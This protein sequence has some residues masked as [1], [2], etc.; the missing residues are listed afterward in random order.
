MKAHYPNFRETLV[1]F[2]FLAFGFTRGQLLAFDITTTKNLLSNNGDSRLDENGNSMPSNAKNTALITKYESPYRNFFNITNPNSSLKRSTIIGS[3]IVYGADGIT[4]GARACDVNGGDTVINVKID[5]NPNTIGPIDA[6]N[7]GKYT[8]S[9]YFHMGISINANSPSLFVNKV[10]FA[11]YTT[12]VYKS[13]STS[14]FNSKIYF[15]TY[16][17]IGIVNITDSPNIITWVTDN[18]KLRS[19]ALPNGNS[20]DKEVKVFFKS[21]YNTLG[22]EML[23]NKS[24]E[25]R[26]YVSRSNEAPY[27]STSTNVTTTNL[28]NYFKNGTNYQPATSFSD[29]SAGEIRLNTFPFAGYSNLNNDRVYYDNLIT[30]PETRFTTLIR[31]TDNP[32]VY[33]SIGPPSIPDTEIPCG[34]T[35]IATS[36]I[37]SSNLYT[38]IPTTTLSLN[39]GSYSDSKSGTTFTTNDSQIA[40]RI[41]DSS[42]TDVT[43]NATL[44]IGT[45]YA[46]YMYDDDNSTTGTD[47]TKKRMASVT[48]KEFHITQKTTTWN[49]SSWNNGTPTLNT[50]V[51]I[52]GNYDTAVNGNLDACNLTVN[53]GYKLDI[54]GNTQVRVSNNIVNNNL[55]STNDYNFIVQNDGNLIQINDNGTFTG[56]LTLY[57]NSAPV[58]KGHYVYWGSPVDGQNL[59]QFSPNTLSSRFYTYNESNDLFVWIDPSLN[60]FSRA[61]GYAIRAPNN[62]YTSVRTSYTGKFQGNPYTGAFTFPIVKSENVIANNGASVEM[63]NT[64]I[65]NPYPSNLDLDKFFTINSGKIYST[66]YFWTNTNYNPPMQGVNYPSNLPTKPVINNYAIYNKSGGTPAPFGWSGGTGTTTTV[67]LPITPNNIVKPGQGF[68][69][70][71]SGTAPINNTISFNNSTRVTEQTKTQFYSRVNSKN[72]TETIDRYW[73]TLK[74]PLDFVTPILIAYK[75][76]ASNVYE[77]DYDSEPLIDSGDNFYSIIP[78]HHLTIQGR[79]GP[80]D[81]NDRVSLGMGIGLEGNHTISLSGKEG[82]FEQGQPI[83]LYDKYLNKEINLQE[84]SYNFASATGIYDDR[85][86]LSY[87]PN[88]TLGNGNVKNQEDILIYKSDQSFYIKS[89]KKINEIL[90][91][92][93]SGKLIKK[94]EGKSTVVNIKFSELKTGVYILDINSEGNSVKKKIINP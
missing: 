40:L 82:K 8:E 49:G 31:R 26:F 62:W 36:D 90:V 53:N 74:T 11:P 83:Y 33:G 24:Y 75:E 12:Y 2:L 94:I 68:V 81:I 57:R 3:T 52:N 93:N 65:S 7:T 44:G 59:L 27:T 47:F 19:C 4:N 1:V 91:Y 18:L 38:P 50:M 79:K 29:N 6:S 84:E 56:N 35:S 37:I 30:P 55:S 92:D 23:P 45:Y 88:T 86:E 76:D 10:T 22:Y 89:N 63:G 58:I 72:N 9:N 16:Y 69:V 73:L 67:T 87:I 34:T 28:P 25:I 70:K 60:S 51:V 14:G 78:D 39:G 48:Y 61:K 20:W 80:L 77:F 43:N 54:K 17:R 13:S 32:M 85:F 41:Y 64:L 66:A 15:N 71:V 42:G 46:A 5:D 21:P